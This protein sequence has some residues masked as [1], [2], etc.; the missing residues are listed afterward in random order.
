MIYA[1]A[2]IYL[3]YFALM[4]FYFYG[5]RKLS[6]YRPDSNGLEPLTVIVPFKNEAANLPG[7]LECLVNQEISYNYFQLIFVD[8]HSND[9]GAKIIKQKLEGK[10]ACEVLLNQGKGKKAAISTGLE[11]AKHNY[12]LTLD[13][14]V[15]IGNNHFTTISRF[16]NKNKPDLLIAPVAISD[17]PR[18]IF[19]HFQK[20]ELQSLAA[21]TAAS[22]YWNHPVMCNGAN[23]IFSKEKLNG[24]YINIV[25]SRIAS[26]D[27]MFLLEYAKLNKWN[28]QYLKNKKA[29]AKVKSLKI[30]SFL[31]QRRRWSSKALKYKHPDIITTGFVV[32]LFNFAYVVNIPLALFYRDFFFLFAIVTSLKLLAEGSILWQSKGF[33]GTSGSMKYLIIIVLLQPFYVFSI[34]LASLFSHSDWKD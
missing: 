33:F 7:L 4:H 13:A 32:S 17:E 22:A 3:G 29:I 2:F 1:F 16:V 19:Q 27:D 26:G 18:S 20:V 21:S 14:D 10:F 23:L 30:K 12:I 34:L 9:E 24:R 11:S 28:I 15:T 8:D 5:W 6:A 31:K 25:Q